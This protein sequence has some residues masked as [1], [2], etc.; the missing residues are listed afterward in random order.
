MTQKYTFSML[1]RDVVGIRGEDGK[2]IV[3]MNMDRTQ[4]QKMQELVNQANLAV[5]PRR[6]H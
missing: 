6:R 1:T 5:A 4:Q 3:V 2:L